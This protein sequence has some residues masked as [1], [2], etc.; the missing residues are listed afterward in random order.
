MLVSHLAFL[1]I[2]LTWGASFILMERATHAFGP[3]GVGIGRLAGG[4]VVLAGV[5]WV[6][7][8]KNLSQNRLKK[9]GQAQFGPKTLQSEPVPNGSDSTHR[10]ARRDVARIAGVALAGTALPFVIQPYCLR[11]GF[12]HS[13][14]GTMVALVPLA[15]IVVSVPT[16][17]VWPTWRQLVGVLGGLACIVLLIED[18]AERGMSAGLLALALTVPLCYAMGNTYLKWKLSHVH[19]VPLTALILALAAAWLAPLELVPGVLERLG[20]AGPTRPEDVALAV[21][22]LA[23]LGAIGTGVAVLLFIHLVVKEGPLFAGM[24]TYVVP[25]L[26]LVWGAVDGEAI[27]ARQLAAIGGV[28]AMVALV[29]FGGGA[30]PAEPAEVEAGEPHFCPSE[31]PAE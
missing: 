31:N 17:G 21:A 26:A 20:L 4:A 5:W 13:Y 9:G 23:V 8:A 24:V 14:F 22:A 6:Q 1:F 18:G 28:L 15:T 29:Q 25:V 3:V 12:G 7:R 19:A 11:Q 10:V 30:A 2:C 27:T 16:L